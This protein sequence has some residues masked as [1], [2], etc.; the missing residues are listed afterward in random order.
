[1][2]AAKKRFFKESEKQLKEYLESI[3]ATKIKNVQQE[4]AEQFTAD[5][6]NDMHQQ[7][8]EIQIPSNSNKHNNS[9]K[10]KQASKGSKLS[11]SI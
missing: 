7:E 6:K 4:L 11:A 1:M 5:V 10:H 3:V 2:A 8:T 9:N